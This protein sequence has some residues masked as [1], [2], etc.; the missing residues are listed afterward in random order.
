MIAQLREEVTKI[1]LIPLRRL[2]DNALAL[3]DLYRLCHED[4]QATE[5]EALVTSICD[6]GISSGLI[7]ENEYDYLHGVMTMH[8]RP[9]I[10]D[11]LPSILDALPASF[12]RT[13]LQQL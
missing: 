2:R 13:H 10:L 7:Y 4:D 3:I 1:G 9:S 5:V 11:A 8:A 6:W 12:S